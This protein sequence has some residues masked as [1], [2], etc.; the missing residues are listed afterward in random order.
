MNQPHSTKVDMHMLTFEISQQP[1]Q[2][3]TLH[4][5]SW[6]VALVPF[7]DIIQIFWQKIH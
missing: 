5:I 1:P 7:C 3:Q 4:K 6:S 2:S